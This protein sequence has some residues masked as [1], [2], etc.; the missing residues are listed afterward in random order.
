MADKFTFPTSSDRI[1]DQSKM[2]DVLINHIDDP[3]L[4]EALQILSDQLSQVTAVLNP[5]AKLVIQ[6]ATPGVDL[7]PPEILATQILNSSVRIEW[8]RPK[9]SAQWTF[10]IRQ[11][12][13]WDTANFVTRTTGTVVDLK[14]LPGSPLVYLIKSI[15]ATG[16][17]S[18]DFTSVPITIAI[19]GTVSLQGKVI[20][21][22]VLLNWTPSFSLLDIDYYEIYKNSV[23]IGTTAS[24]FTVI[25]ET[26]AGNFNYEVVPVDIIGVKGISAAINLSV[27]QPPDYVLTATTK[28]D[29]HGTQINVLVE[30]D[31]NLIGA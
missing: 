15:D 25:F 16:A 6:R 18:D 21:N 5:V 17:Y 22:N 19:P 10:E 31:P 28:S 12:I 14:P 7:V 2:I 30:Y 11:G 9:G 23:L 20:D 26:V 27:N 1:V 3:K 4:F 8:L 24:T 29:F 13:D